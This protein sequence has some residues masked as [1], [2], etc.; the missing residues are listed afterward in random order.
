[1][2]NISEFIN[3]K[4]SPAFNR[5]HGKL[6]HMILEAIINAIK[7]KEISKDDALEMLDD[8]RKTIE[9]EY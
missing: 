1:M 6:V 2:K 4:Y 8:A 9:V 7:K 5:S 3:E